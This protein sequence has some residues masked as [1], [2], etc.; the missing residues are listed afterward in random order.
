MADS[1]GF[2]AKLLRVITRGRLV[3]IVTRKRVLFVCELAGFGLLAFS[4]WLAFG[5]AVGLAALGIVLI[6]LGNSKLS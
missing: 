1:A 3:Q 4:A 5:D 2:L 6:I